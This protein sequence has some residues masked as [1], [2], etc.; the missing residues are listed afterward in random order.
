MIRFLR[1]KPAPANA[2]R[3]HRLLTDAEL[4]QVTGG[5]RFGPGQG[6]ER[7]A[8]PE[9]EFV[10]TP[11]GVRALPTSPIILPPTEG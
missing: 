9:P 11:R 10:L 4:D 7:P 1:S 6:L 3:P 2:E 8:D 5:H